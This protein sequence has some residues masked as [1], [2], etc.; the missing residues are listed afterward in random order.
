MPD[1]TPETL[2]QWRDDAD[3]A[4]YYG[5]SEQTQAERIRAL[6]DALE[7]TRAQL[8]NEA[9]LAS[10]RKAQLATAKA[11]ALTEFYAGR[12]LYC[13]ACYD[14]ADRIEGDDA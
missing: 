7:A 10:Y 14:R 11:D 4:H 6:I 3:E 13:Q 1:L 9:V 12:A 5:G 8:A 2:A